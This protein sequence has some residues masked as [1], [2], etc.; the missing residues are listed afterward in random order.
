[1]AV[2]IVPMA[3]GSMKLGPAWIAGKKKDEIGV[4]KDN[5]AKECTG[6]CSFGMQ[7]LRVR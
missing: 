4:M 1:M 6:G 5:L 3:I 2:N 7:R